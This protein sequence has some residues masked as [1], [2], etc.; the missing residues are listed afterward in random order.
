MSC[1][2]RQGAFHAPQ[3]IG[4]DKQTRLMIPNL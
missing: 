3:H 2:A 4:N 1:K